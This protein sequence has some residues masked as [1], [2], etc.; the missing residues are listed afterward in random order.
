MSVSMGLKY[1]IRVWLPIYYIEIKY[2]VYLFKWSTIL[3]YFDTKNIRKIKMNKTLLIICITALISGCLNMAPVKPEP[4]YFTTPPIYEYKKN[5]DVFG[6]K[7][8]QKFNKKGFKKIKQIG[9]DV[10]Y[11]MTPSTLK[12]RKRK[13]FDHDLL[14]MTLYVEKHTN[15]VRGILVE[16]KNQTFK[17]LSQ[18]KLPFLKTA[19]TNGK[20]AGRVMNSAKVHPLSI[21]PK[22]QKHLYGRPSLPKKSNVNY[23]GHD[24][25]NPYFVRQTA[26]N[27][28]NVFMFTRIS[29]LKNMMDSL[30]TKGSPLET[31]SFF[32]LSYNGSSHNPDGSIRQNDQGQLHTYA[33]D[34]TNGGF[35]FLYAQDF[36]RLG[37][38]NLPSANRTMNGLYSTRVDHLTFYDNELTS[39]TIL[40]AKTKWTPQY[41]Y[42][43]IDNFNYYYADLVKELNKDFGCKFESEFLDKTLNDL[44]ISY[45]KK[46][47]E[48]KDYTLTLHTNIFD[49]RPK[50][51]STLSTSL[52]LEVRIKS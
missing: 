14:N 45:D 13:G 11:E 49:S 18:N 38:L 40:L 48:S 17:Q 46:L 52:S 31:A 3:Y 24:N 35:E 50:G 8:G 1:N 37:D 41:L 9:T 43:D 51:G 27:I 42:T 10:L 4:S 6:F 2:W 32:G 33:I 5:S 34:K 28:H 25:G 23:F 20:N 39:L 15:V 7:L 44:A 36:K 29:S 16:I 47:C 12:N 21:Y 19:S 26:G 30:N 22:K